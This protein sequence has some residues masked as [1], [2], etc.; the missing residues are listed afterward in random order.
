MTT[1][2]FTIKD[3][4]VPVAEVIRLVDAYEFLQKEHAKSEAFDAV[5]SDLGEL[6]K[7][8]ERYG[9]PAGERLIVWACREIERLHAVPDRTAYL[10]PEVLAFARL[11]EQ[12]LRANDHKPGWKSDTPWALMTRLWEETHE[13]AGVVG[14][15]SLKMPRSQEQI[16]AEAAD[17][18]NFALMIA[19]VCGCLGDSTTKSE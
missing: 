12:Q 2:E 7:V 16:G 11:M 8:G 10:R 9:C 6:H 13:L 3:G 18:A 14:A 1:L 17:V 19:D 5:A 4:F 15:S